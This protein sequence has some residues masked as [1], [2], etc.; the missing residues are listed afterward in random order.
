MES[1]YAFLTAEAHPKPESLVTSEYY[2]FLAVKACR[3][4]SSDAIANILIQ[5]NISDGE[6]PHLTVLDGKF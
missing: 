6:G 3:I 2:A 1:H 5:A 4:T